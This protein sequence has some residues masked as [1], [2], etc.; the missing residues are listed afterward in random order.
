M[1]K[2]DINIK[3]KKASFNYEFIE[4]YTAGIVLTGTEIK[5]IREG[6]VNFTDS[7]CVFYGDELWIKG[8]HISEYSYGSYNNHEP[9]RER[10]LLLTKKELLKIKKRIT[11]KG[12]TI[13]PIRLFVNEKGWAKLVI[14]I[15]R[16]KAK[17]DK[18]QDIKA[19]DTKRDLDRLM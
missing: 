2:K 11:E 1:I 9:K 6:R 7:Y 15:A 16:G 14:A 8:L 4:K 18:R 17:Y 19:R 5:A 10:K 3:N 12:L 13:V